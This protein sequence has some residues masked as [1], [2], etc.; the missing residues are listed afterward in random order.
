MPPDEFG[1]RVCPAIDWCD[2]SQLGARAFS[3]V[4]FMAHSPDGSEFTPLKAGCPQLILSGASLSQRVSEG[5]VSE[6]LTTE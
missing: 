2:V 3:V 5:G 1:W 6:S 4:C